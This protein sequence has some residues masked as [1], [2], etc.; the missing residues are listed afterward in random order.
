MVV[1]KT[2][3][4]CW[5]NKNR[6]DGT[7]LYYNEA[8]VDVIVVTRGIRLDGARA[9]NRSCSARATGGLNG[10]VGDA[11]ADNSNQTF[12]SFFVNVFHDTT[13]ST[14]IG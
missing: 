12:G 3:A 2:E 5:V 9:V 6:H 7:D 13:L 11:L 14:G 8:L 1:L 4:V 10:T